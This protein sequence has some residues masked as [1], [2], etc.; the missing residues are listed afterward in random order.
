MK[1][2]NK[3]IAALAMAGF[4]M[5]TTTGCGNGNSVDP[6]EYAVNVQNTNRTSGS[7]DGSVTLNQLE[8]YYI[9]KISDFE[10][11]E[12]FYLT[13]KVTYYKSH[14]VSYD[15]YKISGSAIVLATNKHNS[16]KF[17]CKYGQVLDIVE[18][19]Q[20]IQKYST[21]KEKYNFNEIEDIYNKIV[22]E[23]KNENV[24]KYTLK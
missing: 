22:E 15:D 8:D 14:R 5:G 3:K 9:I 16:E 24:K 23:N 20:Y 13:Y 11:Q 21:I 12:R 18:F 4:L 2:I 6:I 1:E 17:D 19:I 7:L 10:N